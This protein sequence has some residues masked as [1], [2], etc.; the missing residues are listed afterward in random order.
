VRVFRQEFTLEDADGSHAFAPLQASRRVTNAPSLGVSLF[1]P[2][3][4][5]NCIQ[6]LKVRRL[7]K[8]MCDANPQH[9]VDPGTSVPLSAL[10]VTG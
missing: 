10:T 4:T 3:R 8:L 6:T 9:C 1:L 2:V 7:L 5:V